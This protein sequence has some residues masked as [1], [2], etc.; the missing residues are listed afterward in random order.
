MPW[1]ADG[2]PRAVPL[3]AQLSGDEIAYLHW[4]ASRPLVVGTDLIDLGALA[5]GS[6]YALARGAAEHGERA[7]RVVSYDSFVA[8][9]LEVEAGLFDLDPGSSTLGIYRANLARYAGRTEP[10]AMMIPEFAEG[11][12]LNEVYPD[13]LPISVLFIDCAKSWGVHHTI[14][15]AF[16]PCLR[17]G[18]VVVQQDFRGPLVYL[19]L[20]MYQLRHRVRPVHCVDGG[21]V[22]F[23]CES[24]IESAD[25]ERLWRP[26]DLEGSGL[27]DRLTEAGAYF[28]AVS[29]EPLSAWIRLSA[30]FF[31]AR[32]DRPRDAVRQMESAW[33]GLPGV[34]R[35]APGEDRRRTL[36]SAWA[37]AT[38]KASRQL[39]HRGYTDEGRV[40]LSMQSWSGPGSEPGVDDDIRRAL[41]RQVAARCAQIGR[42]RVALYGAGLHTRRLVRSGVLGGGSRIV[43]IIDD[44]PERWGELD[45]IPVTSPDEAP[46]FDVVV[47]S[48]DAHEPML[49]RRA[50][51][52]ASERG[53]QSFPVYSEQ[54]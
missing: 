42:G 23:A 28:D 44:A 15:G 45:R 26:A 46:E 54:A 47:P 41:W 27:D 5:G 24:P 9:A 48:S 38:Q 18:S 35:A 39:V 43:A 52:L 3:T 22:G 4:L 10:R 12:G 49:L 8:S 32:N 1:R 33:A 37:L 14:L 2:Y 13:R 16:G 51:A 40:V 50:E 30:V 7:P 11:E 6:A 19:G 36:A 31:C 25:V 53:V 34:I 17:A 21:S 29:P 20:H